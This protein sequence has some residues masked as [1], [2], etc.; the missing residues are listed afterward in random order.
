MHFTMGP[1][2]ALSSSLAHG[3]S[4]VRIAAVEH[5]V[6]SRLYHEIGHGLGVLATYFRRY[7]LCGRFPLRDLIAKMRHDGCGGRAGKAKAELIT[8]VEGA[9]N[10][11]V[12]KIVLPDG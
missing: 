11:P 5:A 4:F 7:L 12:R 3:G 6:L 1:M 10:R 2:A 9:S 8:G